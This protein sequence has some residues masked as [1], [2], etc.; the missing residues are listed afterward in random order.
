MSIR[1]NPGKAVPSLQR[2][3]TTVKSREEDP[4]IAQKL[5]T[6][7]S[8]LDKIKGLFEDVK[9][10]EYELIDTLKLV[11]DLLRDFKPAKMIE[12]NN[13]ILQSGKGTAESSSGKKEQDSVSTGEVAIDNKKLKILKSELDKILKEEFSTVKKNELK[14]EEMFRKVEDL[15][16]KFTECINP[17]EDANPSEA[18]GVEKPSSI[19]EATQDKKSVE[20]DVSIGEKL[21][22][23]MFEIDT[24]KAKFST[25]EKNDELLGMLRIAEDFLKNFNEK[26]SAD[27]ILKHGED[28]K[29]ND[30]KVVDK[31]SLSQEAKEKESV[32]KNVSI[33]EMFE[34]LKFELEKMK[35][36]FSRVKENEELFSTLKRLEDLLQNINAKTL[37]KTVNPVEAANQSEAK[38]QSQISRKMLV[39]QQKAK[40]K[41]SPSQEAPNKKIVE[42]VVPDDKKVERLKSEIDNMKAKCSSDEEFRMLSSLEDLLRHFKTKEEL[43]DEVLTT[44]H[45]KIKESTKKLGFS[46][47]EDG[48][49]SQAKA[50]QVQHP[51]LS[52][53]QNEEKITLV[54]K[55]FQ[56]S[57]D[58]L[59]LHSKLCCLSLSVFPENVVIKKRHIIYWWIGEGFVKNTAEQTAEEEGEEVFEELLNSYL[60][61]RHGN[62]KCPI[63]NKFKIS[64]WIRHM[65]VSSVLVPKENNQ[66]FE[67]ISEITTAPH[68]NNSSAYL[69]L[70]QQKVKISGEFATDWR[71]VFNLGA[72]YLTIEPQWMA[73]MK[74]IVVLQ[75]GRWQESP[76]HHI[77]VDSINFMKD[78]KGQKHLKYLSLRGISRIVELPPSIAQLVSLQILDVKACHNLETLPNEIASLKNLTHLDASQCYLL[79]SMPK[80]I[81]KLSELQVFKGFVVGNSDKTP[82]I[83]DLVKFKKLKRLGVHIGSQAVIQDRD[84][85]SLKDLMQVKCLKISWGVLSTSSY[86]DKV[87]VIFLPPKLEKLDLEGFP[88]EEINIS[89]LA[90]YEL[91][92]LYIKGGKL[93]SLAPFY[94]VR[95]DIMRLKHLNNLQVEREDLR[96]KFPT[97]KYA[98]V[99]K[100]SKNSFEW[101]E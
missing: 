48:S 18:K 71:S 100:V 59:G 19:Q 57:Y 51:P 25:V 15:L 73:K 11:D 17:T 3:L 93:K 45:E 2:R 84:F 30:A 63:V 34:S 44:I 13:R 90:T 16:R 81:E 83:S 60:I 52:L 101:P 10:N 75:L 38:L 53:S 64:P 76:L 7:M 12:I 56:A 39:V 94:W 29:E 97:L 74:K 37:A 62:G 67:K 54:L 88:M 89:E 96:E 68:L 14:L 82:G 79:E 35:A 50:T 55:R 1:T 33:D 24:M 21:D 61:V 85:E 20:K 87:N 28:S 36:N 32:E 65:L 98:E 26:N 9:R 72:S 4:S 46:Q 5:E 91:K 69:V 92:K 27:Q 31:S 41:P 66:P 95:V 86:K 77:E 6:L 49:S 22:S 80:G 47:S 23:L 8:E 58:A 99:K 40:D 70:D 42:K 78:L 43:L